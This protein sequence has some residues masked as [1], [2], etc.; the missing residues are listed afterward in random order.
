M[1]PKGIVRRDEGGSWI[2]GH[3]GSVAGYTAYLCFDP[4]TQIGV[5]LLRNYNRGANE[6]G[7]ACD[8]DRLP[9]AKPEARPLLLF[10]EHKQSPRARAGVLYLQDGGCF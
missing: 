4:E 8:R 9:A 2:V 10:N 3:E 5:V 7:S 1:P 6:P